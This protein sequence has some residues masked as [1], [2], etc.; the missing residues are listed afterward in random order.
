[1]SFAADQA[2]FAASLL[3]PGSALPFNVTTARGK[4]DAARFAVYRNNVF[5]GLT[6]V[7]GRR[8]PVTERLVGA[9]F[10]RGMA[11]AYV[12]DH[13]PAS[14]LLFAY[15]D[16]FPDFI[17][18]FPPAAGLPY[19]ADV[20][21]LE[22]GWT[23][24]YYAADAAPLDP[25]A[26]AGLTP[27]VLATAQMVPHPATRL[28]RSQYPVGSI[29]AA[30]QGDVLAPPPAWRP[31]TVLVTRPEIAVRVH[32]LPPSH[33]GFVAAL[34]AGMPLIRAA[35]AAARDPDFD[36]GSALVGLV[37]VG[38]FRAIHHGASQ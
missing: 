26:L 10:F 32:V 4:P 30:H 37:S 14:P 19:L 2:A 24:A 13:K 21:R 11:R 34:L 8:F 22:A 18:G 28:V 38:A 29:W 3:R 20:A 5:V 6:R 27:D 16:D 23:D 17:A 7:L 9:D 12:E 31:E 33:P 15:G 36:F 35:E 25:A 1:M